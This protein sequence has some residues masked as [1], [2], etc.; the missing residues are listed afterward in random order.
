MVLYLDTSAL[1]KCYVKESGSVETGAAVE[2]ALL[3]GTVVLSRVEISAAFAKAVRMGSL[4]KREARAAL[5]KFREEWKDLVRIQVTDVLVNRADAY[6]W[7]HGLRG[8]DALQLTAAVI[9]Q[10]TLGEM[11]TFATYDAHLMRAAA[12]E[13]LTPFPSKSVG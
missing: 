5:E 13:G 1:V 2:E 3:V 6:A 7:E 8:Y 10:E 11:I 4:M 9:W 12:K